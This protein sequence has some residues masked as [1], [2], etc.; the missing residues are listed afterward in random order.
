MVRV[1]LYSEHSLLIVNIQIQF[2]IKNKFG[3]L[4][5]YENT[6]I[7]KLTR[8]YVLSITLVLYV[9]LGVDNAKSGI[10]YIYVCM[11]GMYAL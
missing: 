4:L 11:D 9:V 3:K 8:H 2:E 1:A 7:S 5:L 6:W 10:C